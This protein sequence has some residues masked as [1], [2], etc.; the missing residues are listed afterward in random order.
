[1]ERKKSEAEQR[2]MENCTFSPSLIGK[3]DKTGATAA[4]TGKE[5]SSLINYANFLTCI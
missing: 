2:D 3:K 1:M 5:Y 4:A